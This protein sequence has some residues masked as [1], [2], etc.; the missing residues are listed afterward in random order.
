MGV[1]VT[2]RPEG[3][4]QLAACRNAV[5]VLRYHA[6]LM[7]V[8]DRLGPEHLR[9]VI[10]GY[11]DALAAHREALNR[12][13]V[14]PVP[15]GDTGTNMALTLESV[16]AELPPASSHPD[17]S[18]ICKAVAHGSLMGARGNSGVILSQVMRGL[19]DGLAQVEAA[20]GATFADA[21]AVSAKAAY[22]AVMHPVEGTILT[23]IREAADA[24]VA[25]RPPS[26]G[27][28]VAS[29]R[30]S[31]TA[32]A[33]V[34]ELHELSSSSEPSLTSAPVSWSSAATSPISCCATRRFS[35]LS[36]G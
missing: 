5:T 10:V 26:A 16:V 23:V 20:D 12:L 36:G 4:G 1:E 6:S 22:G 21:L 27:S 8:L 31:L 2:R 15:D 25:S 18:A 33:A 28:S 34:S 24:A 17:L 3:A 19:T 11:R 13:N 32:V 35:G 14:Y 30:T 9:A 7:E 29:R